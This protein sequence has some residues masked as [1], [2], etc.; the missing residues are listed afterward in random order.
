MRVTV[1]LQLSLIVASR[2]VRWSDDAVS[3]RFIPLFPVGWDA[4][5]G[6]LSTGTVSS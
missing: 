4:A 2:P 5:L 6:L 1:K 3:V